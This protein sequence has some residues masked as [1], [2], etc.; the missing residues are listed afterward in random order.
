LTVKLGELTAT[1]DGYIVDI[2]DRIVLTGAF[3]DTDPEIGNELS[4]LGVAA[5]QF[6]TNA[7]DTR[8]KGLDVV[9]SHQFYAGDQRFAWS[10][11][12][13]FN[14]MEL[15][16]IHTTAKLA[17]KEDIYFGAREQAFLL[18]SA[19]S[20]KLTFTLDHRFR[21]FDSQLRVTNFG[22]V[23]LI[24]WVDTRDVYKAKAVT[25]L[26]VGYRVTDNARLTVGAANLFNVYPTQQDTETESGGLWDAVQMG[27]GGSFYF[28]RL[29][30][31]L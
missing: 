4:A 1:I 23:S 2:D 18:A 10:V 6:F 20:S 26:S 25:D 19:P 15:G 17:G 29:S 12:G 30:L 7:L 13:N 16:D 24:D 27:F 8:T 11:A 5:A 31:R 14:D 28:A 21:R 22:R 3:E 9:V